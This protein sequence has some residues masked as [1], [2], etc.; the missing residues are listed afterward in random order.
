MFGWAAW[1]SSLL[2]CLIPHNP[3]PLPNPIRYVAK[4]AAASHT[5]FGGRFA[6]RTM[7]MG[8]LEVRFVPQ[9]FSG[10]VVESEVVLVSFIFVDFRRV[11]MGERVPGEGKHA[12]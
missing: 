12:L 8:L 9:S 7:V 6:G 11:L 4:M 2:V 5:L 3:Y 10:V 1:S